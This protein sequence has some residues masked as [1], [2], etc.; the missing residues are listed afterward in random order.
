MREVVLTGCAAITARGDFHQNAPQVLEAAGFAGG[1]IAD[2][3]LGKY[4]QSSKTYLD[5]CSALALAGCASALKNASQAWPVEDSDR[6]GIALGT[7]DGCLET[8]RAFWDSV[9][10]RGVEKANSILFSHSYLNSPISLCAIE[11][12][13]RGHHGTYS[14]DSKSGCDAVQIAFDAIRL[15]HADAMLC[16]GVEALTLARRAC[17]SQHQMSEASCFFVL[18]S[19]ERAQNRGVQVLADVS[20]A[21]FEAADIAR[22]AQIFGDCGGANGALALMKASVDLPRVW[23]TTGFFVAT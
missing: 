22:A 11:F 4:L 8:M 19:K 16:G 13:L 3:V 6:F 10:E 9:A 23:R 12:G 17:E 1:A 2:F 21:W 18:E 14:S 7:H 20:D 15:G 5:R